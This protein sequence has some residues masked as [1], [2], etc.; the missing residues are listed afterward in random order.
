MTDKQQLRW[1]TLWSDD[2]PTADAEKIEASCPSSAAKIWFES[3]W[4][5][6]GRP[7]EAR[8]LVR[9]MSD[10]H[11]FAFDVHV[12]GIELDMTAMDVELDA[13]G[14]P[15]DPTFE[16]GEPVTAESLDRAARASG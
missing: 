6:L 10:Q 12:E 1:Y 5:S 16:P 15:I 8:V 11:L 7:D 4:W 2:F 9:R 3:R 14:K 13:N